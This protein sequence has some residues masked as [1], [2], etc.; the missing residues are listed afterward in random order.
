MNFI[1]TEEGISTSDPWYDLFDGGYFKPKEI[2]VDKKES[3]KVE[4]AIKVVKQFMR[5]AEETGHIVII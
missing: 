3:K 1:E 4:Y 5:E 2:I